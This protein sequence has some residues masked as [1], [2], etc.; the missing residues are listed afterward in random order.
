M[1]DQIQFTPK[2]E[3]PGLTIKDLYYKYIRFL[4]FFVLSAALALLS[5]YLYLRYTEP[6]YKSV[7]S[8]LLKEDKGGESSTDRFQQ[9]FVLDNSININNE[10]E[11]LK[12]KEL[13]ERVVNKLNLSFSFTAKGKIRNSQLYNEVPFFIEVININD[14]STFIWNITFLKDGHY[15]I[16]EGELKKPGQLFTN[17]QGS[18]RLIRRPAIAIDPEY[19]KFEVKWQP[20]DQVASF[21]ASTISV[22][23]K[24][25]T[26]ILT[27]SLE[28]KH[29]RLAADVINTLMSEYSVATI[30]DK[31]ET[32]PQ[33]IAFVDD[34]LKVVSRELDSV[35][36]Q[37]LAYQHANNIIDPQS[38]ASRYFTRLEN[39]DQQT[40]D[41]RV[42]VS[43]MQM[44]EDYLKDSKNKYN[45]VPSTLGV[46]DGTLSNLISAY[47]VIQMDRKALVDGNV[48]VTNIKVKELEDRLERV[49]QNVLENLR[50]IKNAQV[51]AISRLQQQASAF[52]TEIQRIPAKEQNLQEIQRQ[53]QTKQEVYNLLM[54]KREES[55]ISLAATI[56][57]IKV[58]EKAKFTSTPVKPNRRTVQ[59]IA[60]IVGLALPALIIFL[61]EA[62]NDKVSSRV[63]VERITDATI[64]GDVGHSF[65]KEALV[66]KPNN[67]GIVAEQFRIIRSNLQYVL[68]HIEKP[69]IMVTS[70]FSGEGKSFISTNL[71]SVMALAGKRT[72]ILEF[73]IRKPKILSHLNM[74]K[75]PGL[76]N[77]LL[78]KTQLE[79]LPV[80]IQDIEHLFVLPCGP[81]PPNPAEMLLDPKLETLFNYLKQE[82]DV[83][84]IDTAPVGMVSDALTLSKYADVTLYL[85]RQGHTLKKQITLVD[86]FFKEGKLP[87]LSIILND[88]KLRGYGY[89]YG[90]GYSYGAGYFEDEFQTNP[91][92]SRWLGWM[93]MK[94]WQKKKRKKEKV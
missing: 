19:N 2:K 41:A 44:I 10:I 25:A 43:V 58:L 5:A 4:P 93:D 13:M 50:N 68:N 60:L 54:E 35:T 29:P 11:L 48:P 42:Q 30:E 34:R 85:V 45:L 92:L 23:P 88:V 84:V 26:G 90:Y 49:R 63:D 46:Q 38:Q 72:I 67:R 69:V 57:N 15:R 82:F 79:E 36:A 81:V 78:G 37:L 22:V 3:A 76:T 52:N 7:G 65:S 64:L 94:K 53:L 47:N 91:V 61:I 80:P 9:L 71:G 55:A 27:L 31:N 6:V 14:S 1:E 28:S 8:L 75:K 51:T 77:Y 73:D 87:K 56:S 12:S 86:Q 39:L 40:N 59:L 17:A 70:S 16:N 18:F 21:Y 74:A 32:R 33:T 83:I 89:G 20:A 62:L 24:G 66:V